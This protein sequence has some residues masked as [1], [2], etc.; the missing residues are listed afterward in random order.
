MMRKA[1]NGRRLSNYN[2][3]RGH[4]EVDRKLISDLNTVKFR[5][6]NTLQCGDI[7]YYPIEFSREKGKIRDF[8]ATIKNILAVV[9]LMI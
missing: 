6:C 3:I 8:L 5:G 7:L 9:F 1:E 4:F 2:K